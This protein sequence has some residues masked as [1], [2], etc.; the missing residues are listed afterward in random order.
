M[1]DH[2]LDAGIIGV[3]R[4]LRRSQ[5]VFVVEDVEALVLHRPH[6][7]VGDGDDHENIEIVFAAEA[8][9]VPAH[10]A[11]ERV[12]GIAAAALLAGLDIDA[13][14]DVAPGHGAEFVFDVGELAADQRKQIGG[15]LERVVPGGEVAAA[16][17]IARIDKVAVRQQHRR[18][19]FVGLD[20]RGVDR[21]HVGAVGEVGDAAEA[22]GLALRAVIAAGAVEPGKL[23]IGGRVDQRLDLQREGAVR[24]LRDGEGVGRR[25]IIFR[26]QRGAVD[27]QRHQIDAVAVELQRRRRILRIRPQ[28][29]L[30]AHH[31]LGRVQ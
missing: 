12:H 4:G 15:L 22:L 17:Q 27:L 25:Q 31:G 8:L 3:G 1:R 29:Q 21:H 20:A 30:G 16:G 11:L 6:V 10:G 19:G 28:R 24:R 13:Q 9:L 23:G 7:E 18:F 14:R 2:R 5:H 26:G